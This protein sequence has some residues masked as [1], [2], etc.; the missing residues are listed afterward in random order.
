MAIPETEYSS[1]VSINASEFSKIC[2]EL[3]SLNETMTVSTSPQF[4]QFSVESEAGSG[5]IKLG[6]NDGGSA[7]E[8]TTLEVSEA[9][10]QQFAIR[11]LNMFNKAAPL[12]TFTRLCLHNEQPL[13]VEYKIENLGVLKY[14][15]APKISDEN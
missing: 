6:Q 4:V 13:V 11:Y 12:T 3:Y 7:D 1:V 9:V 2:K 14:Y 5:S 8:K 10:T 15:L